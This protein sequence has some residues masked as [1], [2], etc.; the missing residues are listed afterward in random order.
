MTWWLLIFYIW[1]CEFNRSR[2]NLNC[3]RVSKFV[4]IDVPNFDFTYW[5]ILWYCFD[6]SLL[7]P[8]NQNEATWLAT[9]LPLLSCNCAALSYLIQTLVF[10]YT[11]LTAIVVC[12]KHLSFNSLISINTHNV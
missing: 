5:P 3:T 2:S 11:L 10:H 1:R 9:R 7:V 4:N 8:A 12:E 6:L